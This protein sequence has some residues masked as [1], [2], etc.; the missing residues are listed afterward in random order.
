M[1]KKKI[2]YFLSGGESPYVDIPSAD[3][4]TGFNRSMTGLTVAGQLRNSDVGGGTDGV[5]IVI[6]SDFTGGMSIN[7]MDGNVSPYRLTNAADYL[8]GTTTKGIATIGSVDKWIFQGKDAET[9]LRVGATNSGAIGWDW[10]GL[11]GG[12]DLT[13]Q[14]AVIEATIGNGFKANDGTNPYGTVD[15]SFTRIITSATENYYLGSTSAVSNGFE[16]V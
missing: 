6:T 7:G 4:T 10:L 11:A 14:N 8:I 15:I 5:D 2:F 12:S 1:N 9:P 13:I 16:S 3:F